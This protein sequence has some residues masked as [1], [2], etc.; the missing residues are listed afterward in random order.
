MERRHY[1]ASI[2]HDMTTRRATLALGLVLTALVILFAMP[3]NGVFETRQHRLLGTILSHLAMLTLL[4]GAAPVLRRGVAR[5]DDVETPT[6][7][8]VLALGIVA[9]PMALMAVR[10]AAPRVTSQLVT[11]E[12]GV[13]E[14]LQVALYVSALW[15]CLAVRGHLAGNP[16]AR[17]LYR[18]GAVVTVILILEEIDYLAVLNLFVRAA[19]APG[20]RLG[21]KHIGGLHDVIDAWTQQAGLWVVA[22]SVVVIVAAT[23]LVLWILLGGY[24]VALRREATRPA[25]AFLAVFVAALVIAQIIDIDDE[26]VLTGVR[27]VGL[28]EEPMELA[29]ALALNAALILRLRDARKELRRRSGAAVLA[30]RA[31]PPGGQ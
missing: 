23:L 7:A 8:W 4:W 13:V 29:A 6:L 2:V 1:D 9:L 21:R 15:L 28:L 20:G 31:E 11:R 24:R 27:P 30:E 12:W 17:A 16:H 25:T 10:V 22:A 18:A 19:G 26:A 5:L 3:G 14:P